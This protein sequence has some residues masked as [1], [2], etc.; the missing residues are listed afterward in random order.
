MFK[1]LRNETQ[2]ERERRILSLWKE[3][4]IY[5]KSLETRKNCPKYVFYDGPPFATGLPHYGHLLAATIKDVVLRYKTMKGFYVP[6]RI[7]WDCHGL[8]VE[9]EIEKEHQLTGA[10]S[11]EEFGI[12]KFNEACRAIVL[13]YT[14][15]WEE[16]VLRMGRF[17]D[18]KNTYRTMDK[19]F[20]ESVW[21]VFKQLFD[22]GL[23]YEGFKVMPYS[24][25]LGTPL[26]NFEAGENY[27]DVDDP[28]LTVKMTLV[29][30]PKTSLLIWTTTPWTLV[31]NLAVMVSPTM[32]YVKL[33]DKTSDQNLILG[34]A[35]LAAHFPDA[36]TYEILETFTG[37]DLEGLRYEPVFSYFSERDAFRVILEE[38]VTAEEGTGLVHSSPA[39]GEV[40]FY[41]CQREGIELVCPVDQNG[42]FTA[43]V[44]EYQGLFVKDADKDIAK[45]LKEQGKLFKQETVNHRYPFCWRS[46]TPLIY[47]AMQTWF[48]GVEKV[49]ET[50]IN[51][52]KEIQWVPDFLKEGRFGK[53]LEGARDWAI[54][55]NRYWGT[56]IPLWRSEEG[57]LH[58]IGSLEELEALTGK[59]VDDLHRHYIDDLTFT[60]DGKLFRRIPEVFDCWFE[61]GSMPYAQNHYPFENKEEFEKGFPA[62]FIAEGLDQ[63]R[64]WFYTLN[65]LSAALF[66][67]P[68]FKNVIVNGIIL[69]EDGTKM[70][71]RLK[72]YPEPDLVMQKYG[73]DAIRL[74]LLDSPVAKASDIRFSEKGVE[75]VLRQ[76]MIPLWNA[77]SFFITYA[78]IAEWTPKESHAPKTAI[79]RWIVSKVHQLI[80]QVE[81]GLDQYDLTMAVQPFVGFIDQLTNWYI[82]RSRR[83]FWEEEATA[84]RSEALSTLYTVL[85]ELSKV[86]APILPFISEAIYQ[87]L[88]TE[89]MA[90]SVHLADYPTYDPGK[91]DPDLE[92]A[93]FAVQSVASLGHALRKEHKLKV[94]Q[95]LQELTVADGTGEY[96]PFLKDQENI[97]L[98]ELNIKE[99][100]LAS[101]EEDLVSLT[102]KPN[103]PLLGRRLGKKMKLAKQVI[104]ALPQ[105]ELQTLLSGSPLTLDLEGESF[106]LQPSE[107][108]LAREVKEGLV[109]A[110]EGVFTVALNTS[111]TPEL[112][113]EALAREVVNKVN[114]MRRD[115]RF[116]VTDRIELTLDTTDRVKDAFEKWGEYIAGEVLAESVEFKSCEGQEWDLN[117][118][119]AVILITRR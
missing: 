39:F 36:E 38:G 103:F 101:S 93:M 43:D 6:R 61:S 102:A 1:E 108:E 65:V 16:T 110:N 56:P 70:S 18:F 74:Y 42:A 4:G 17:V 51:V 115:L 96:L 44:P 11:I 111:L 14:S 22:K 99:L 106:E 88:K 59:K 100:K 47:R 73:A 112:E 41:A 7:G 97:L 109:A 98:D 2:D 75:L 77:F 68:A 3:R 91:R 116:E 67:K 29:D 9:N 66:K 87:E 5:E 63:T 119:K 55:R 50:L 37:Q 84:D 12:A 82:R 26:S 57:D 114:T 62:D 92:K 34:R 21:W 52:N 80:H 79:D 33:Y 53:W 76:L 60:K 32:E 54:S 58:A 81:E 85:L 45:R 64:G 71:K 69:A 86:A 107:V 25:K 30:D 72:N 15:E 27:K 20:M 118:E 40:D 35:A 49:K 28:S 89:E 94:R 23:V 8:P 90:E 78:R 83:R 13:R 10:K 19:D 117:G 113:V 46:D 31:S 95:P 24:A 105:A 104:E 48:V